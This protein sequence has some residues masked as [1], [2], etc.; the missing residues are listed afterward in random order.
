MVCIFY[1]V[2]QWWLCHK[3]NFYNA[4]EY[5]QELFLFLCID[6]FQLPTTVPAINRHSE[7]LNMNTFGSVSK[8]YLAIHTFSHFVFP[9][10]LFKLVDIKLFKILSYYIFKIPP[11][12]NENKTKY[13][14]KSLNIIPIPNS[15]CLFFFYLSSFYFVCL[16]VWI[17][18]ALGFSLLWNFNKLTNQGL[19]LLSHL[20]NFYFL[21][22]FSHLIIFLSALSFIYLFFE[23]PS[24]DT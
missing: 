3:S 23:P 14:Q 20:F 17:W 10:W 18:L 8:I 16:F 6:S 19:A 7:N 4:V 1:T 24:W 11:V 9:F 2:L 5:K 13:K 12:F 22:H 21:S 15:V